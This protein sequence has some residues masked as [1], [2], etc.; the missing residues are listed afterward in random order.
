MVEKFY[1]Y[2]YGNR[3]NAYE[4][5]KKRNRSEIVTSPVEKAE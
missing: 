4:A 2:Y 3:I 5:L 1:A